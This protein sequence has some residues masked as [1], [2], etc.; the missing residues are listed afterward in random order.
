MRLPAVV[1]EREVKLAEVGDE[2]VEGDARHTAFRMP[3]LPVT[4]AWP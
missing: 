1:E 2:P 4:S 3:G